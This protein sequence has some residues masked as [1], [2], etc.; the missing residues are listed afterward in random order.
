METTLKLAL[1]RELYTALVPAK[2]SLRLA[3]Q[4]GRGKPNSLSEAQDLHS[5]CSP[6]P[7]FENNAGSWVFQY[8]TYG[9]QV[10]TNRPISLAS[11]NWQT[12]RYSP[13]CSAG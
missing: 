13:G 3:L 5:F 11:G 6:V 9:V 10:L 8:K 12:K 1:E 4:G 2:Y 7:P